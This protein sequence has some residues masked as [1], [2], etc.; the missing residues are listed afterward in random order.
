M[1]FSHWSTGLIGFFTSRLS[2]LGVSRLLT[3]GVLLGHSRRMITACWQ[4]VMETLSASLAFCEGNHWRFVRGIYQWIC[5]TKGHW[6]ERWFPLHST[7][8]AVEQ[9]V[10]MSAWNAKPLMCQLVNQLQSEI[11]NYISHIYW[12]N[13]LSQL[14]DISYNRT[15]KCNALKLHD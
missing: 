3:T 13:R 7:K 11:W 5:L 4:H 10:K 9:L 6:C 15:E 12:V 8:Q 1:A 14:F 2:H